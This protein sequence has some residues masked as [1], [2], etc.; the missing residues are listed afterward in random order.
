M[1]DDGYYKRNKDCCLNTK[2]IVQNRLPIDD[3]RGVRGM[4]NDELIVNNEN[5]Q[6]QEQSSTITKALV[7]L[8]LRVHLFTLGSLHA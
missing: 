4:I 8:G 1:P 2:H 7:R 3:T 6:V 5:E